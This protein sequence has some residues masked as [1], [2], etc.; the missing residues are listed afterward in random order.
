MVSFCRMRILAFD[1]IWT[2]LCLLFFLILVRGL[3]SGPVLSEN[4]TLNVAPTPI[5]ASTWQATNLSLD[6]WPPRIW[7]RSLNVPGSDKFWTVA[8]SIPCTTEP[9]IDLETVL[10]SVKDFQDKLKERY[11]DPEQDVPSS[12]G[13]SFYELQSCTRWTFELYKLPTKPP[14]QMKFLI[15]A[16]RL[17]F[18][19]L[20]R[21]GA[22]GV[23][24]YIQ[25][26]GYRL[27]DYGI[28]L[29]VEVLGGSSCSA[30]QKGTDG[31]KHLDAPI[32]SRSVSFSL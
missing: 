27:A 1:N 11:P 16:I 6:V 14:I 7:S 32:N 28:D 2:F 12:S 15:S 25:T 29:T 9:K 8:R 24:S 30:L 3:P 13:G 23:T 10:E 21:Y 31:V 18:I 22:A 5:R 17:L 19:A 4:K 20:A 26:P